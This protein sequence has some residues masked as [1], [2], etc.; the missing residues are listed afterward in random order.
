MRWKNFRVAPQFF[1]KFKPY[2]LSAIVAFK[3]Q[4]RIGLKPLHAQSGNERKTNL[5]SRHHYEY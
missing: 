4:F 5:N 1:A 3:I 2:S